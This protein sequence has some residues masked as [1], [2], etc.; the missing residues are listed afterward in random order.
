MLNAIAHITAELAD[1]E[2]QRAE[3]QAQCNVW[4]QKLLLADGA[5]QACVAL[6]KKLDPPKDLAPLA[7]ASTTEGNNP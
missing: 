4:Q 1:Y 5:Y 7:G 2:K 6:L 3:A